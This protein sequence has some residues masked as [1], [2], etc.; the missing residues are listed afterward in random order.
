MTIK[1]LCCNRKP[2]N[3]FGVISRN[4]SRIP[5]EVIMSAPIAV[6]TAAD[7][8]DLD[9]QVIKDVP[10]GHAL[11]ACATDDGCAPSCASACVTGGV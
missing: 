11:A 10:E 6:E 5:R 2:R 1:T 4:M 3:A 7:P 9:V 8:F